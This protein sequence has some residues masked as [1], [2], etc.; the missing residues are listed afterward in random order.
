MPPDI[1]FF[2]RASEAEVNVISISINKYGDLGDGYSLQWGPGMRLVILSSGEDQTV[3]Y[4]PCG[5]PL[6]LRSNELPAY[7]GT[8]DPWKLRMRVELDAEE[9]NKMRLD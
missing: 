9:W 2:R 5:V 1:A 4:K 7:L 8:D 6:V 3:S